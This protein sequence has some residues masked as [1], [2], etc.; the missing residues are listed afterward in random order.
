MYSNYLCITQY[1]FDTVLQ[2]FR[3]KD[4]V[5]GFLT[6][7]VVVFFFFLIHNIFLLKSVHMLVKKTSNTGVIWYFEPHGVI[8]YFEP[9]GKLN[10]GSIYL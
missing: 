1:S 8:W 7:Y 9:H 4:A 10:P 6:S 3:T 2:I 5:P